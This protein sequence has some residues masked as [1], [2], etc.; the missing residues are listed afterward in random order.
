VLLVLV[1]VVLVLVLVLAAYWCWCWCCWRAA[2][3]DT[4]KHTLH[5]C[6]VAL[7][8]ES[9]AVAMKAVHCDQPQAHCSSL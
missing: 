3:G 1:L 9:T 7:C 2:P 8:K 4:K 5:W 6:P